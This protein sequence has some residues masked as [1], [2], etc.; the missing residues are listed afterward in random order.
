L[1]D[2][3]IQE[4]ADADEADWLLDS[5]RDYLTQLRHYKARKAVSTDDAAD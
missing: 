1:P 4:T 5:Q 2:R 3:P